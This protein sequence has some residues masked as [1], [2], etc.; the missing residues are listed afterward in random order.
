MK[1]FL[2]R[3]AEAEPHRA[4]DFSRALTE[5]GEAQACKVGKFCLRNELIP[6]LILSSPLVR[7]EQTARL[8]ANEMN[9]AEVL[10]APWLASGMQPE[11]ALV[12]LAAFTK[13]SS[14]MLVGHEPDFSMLACALLGISSSYGV[15]VRKASLTCLLTDFP[16]PGAATLDF[17]VPV[18]FM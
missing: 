14:V 4:T 16:R 15:N 5:K 17:S 18:K 8:A 9:D 13:F 11:T 6:E 3:H 2:L 7:A 10:I 1:L 12:E